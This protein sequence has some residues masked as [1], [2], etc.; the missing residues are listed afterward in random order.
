MSTPDVPTLVSLLDDRTSIS[1][2]RLYY[3]IDRPEGELPL[4]TGGRF[5]FLGG[6]GDRPDTRD[7]VTA[8][9]LVA[10][11]LL[12]MRIPPEVALNLLE[13]RLGVELA[14]YLSQIDP[15]VELDSDAARELIRPGAAAEAAWHLLEDQDGVG[16]VIASKLLARKRPRL[17]PVYDGVVRC[18]L[19]S[20]ESFW[21]Y[22]HNALRADRGRLRTHLEELRDQAGVPEGTSPLRVLDVV[23]WMR[24]RSSHLDTDCP[25]ID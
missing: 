6:G 13:G 10:V 18:V 16:W 22:L 9:D 11:Q 14:G 21:E 2:L 24:H 23:L 19:G 15:R 4:F 12:G 17:V 25:G 3:G 8:T 1:D 5:D 20:P 7:T